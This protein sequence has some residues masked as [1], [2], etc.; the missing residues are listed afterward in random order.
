MSDENMN[1]LV[2]ENGTRYSGGLRA[3][4]P[5]FESRLGQDFSRLHSFQTESETT[6]YSVGSG[7]KAA[8]AWN[9]PLPSSAEVK[10]G[11]TPPPPHVFMA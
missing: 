1:G 11:G 4:R 9:W 3:G 10:N 6:S 8:G 5:G 7:G 2:W